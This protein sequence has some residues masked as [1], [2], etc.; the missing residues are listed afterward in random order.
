MIGTD[1]IQDVC[2]CL[3]NTTM[4]HRWHPVCIVSLQIIIVQ[5]CIPH[6]DCL[7]GFADHIK[8]ET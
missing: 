8:C 4:Y 1:W 6:T 7:F 2:I 3:Y 5:A